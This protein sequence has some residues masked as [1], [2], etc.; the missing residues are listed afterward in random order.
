V[1]AW[2]SGNSLGSTAR[3][4]ATIS[5]IGIIGRANR[6]SV[7]HLPLLWRSAPGRV[8]ETLDCL[9]VVDVTPAF[10]RLACRRRE[11]PTRAFHAGGPELAESEAGG[12]TRMTIVM[13]R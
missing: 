2:Y 7:A 12:E 8:A 3:A 9:D 4:R 1:P 5:R 6:P 10:P 11:R 13:P